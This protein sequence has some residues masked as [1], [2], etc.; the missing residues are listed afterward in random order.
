MPEYR[1]N[2][3]KKKLSEGKCATVFGGLNTAEMIDYMGQFGFDGA[4]IDTEHSPNTWEQIAHMTR[5]CDLWGMTSLCRVNSNEPWLITR[6][7]DVGATGI[8]VPHV[9]TKEQAEKAAKSAKYGPLGYRGMAAGR[10][11]YGVTDY[12]RKANEQT[13]LVVYIE[14]VEAVKNLDEILTVDN[15]DV[16]LPGPFDLASDMGYTGQPEHPEVVKAVDECVEKILAAGKV[17]GTLGSE[18]IIERAIG[19]GA[20]FLLSGWQQWVAKGATQ[21]LSMVNSKV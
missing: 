13:L 17:A 6:M 18:A 14:E 9:N 20:R 16:F 12:Y 4:W 7:L 1:E 5:A 2:R 3:M 8:V 21:Y 10:Q 19:Q 15:I 11:S